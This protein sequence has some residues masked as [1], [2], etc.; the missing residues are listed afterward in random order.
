M[1]FVVCG[2]VVTV[3]STDSKLTVLK[4]MLNNLDKFN[5]SRNY[6]VKMSKEK[7]QTFC[8]LEW[9]TFKIG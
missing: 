6:E 1:V 3:G 5:C 8:K 2:T 9:P 4:Y 7:L